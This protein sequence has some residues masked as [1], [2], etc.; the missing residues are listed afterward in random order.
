[1]NAY[2]PVSLNIA[3]KRC[4]VI[5]GGQVALRKVNSLLECQARV[6]VISPE[7]CPELAGLAEQ[8]LIELLHR[9]FQPGDLRDV[10]MAVAATDDETVNRL[11]YEEGSR[12]GALVN[13]VDNADLSDFIVPSV[14][15]RGD[16]TISIST[17]GES[18]AL[19]RKI[20]TRLESDF[21]DEYGVLAGL[22]AEV[23]AELKILGLK[24][25]AEDWQQALRL[26]E[27][28]ELVRS[29]EMRQVK[30]CLLA[31]L[32]SSVNSPGEVGKAHAI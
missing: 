27:L 32:K 19:A 10:R 1:M 16:I 4:V 21:G 29:G 28:L 14:L 24:P 5:G 8:D 6:T 23:R 2:Y 12:A 9:G 7:V 18:P 17:S 26:E 3:G 31:R 11:V 20:R 30:E 13:V 22:I 25:S 15:R